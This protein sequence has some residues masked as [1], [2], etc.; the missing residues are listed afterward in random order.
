MIQ[1]IIRD[2]SLQN[3]NNFMFQNLLMIITNLKLETENIV[4]L[5]GNN[6]SQIIDQ[7]YITTDKDRRVSLLKVLINLVLEASEELASNSY[8]FKKIFEICKDQRSDEKM[9]QNILWLATSLCEQNLFNKNFH[10]II[11]CMVQ[12]QIMLIIWKSLCSQNEKIVL[13]ALKLL[14]KLADQDVI[15]TKLFEQKEIF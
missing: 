4:D 3:E 5:I 6:Y 9:I 14:T 13:Q 15:R 7:I 11:E 8:L 2:L 10:L 1:R 12:N